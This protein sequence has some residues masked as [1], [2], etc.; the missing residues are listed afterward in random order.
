MLIGDQTVS[1]KFISEYK[2]FKLV[3]FF[4]QYIEREDNLGKVNGRNCGHIKWDTV[5]INSLTLH[6]PLLIV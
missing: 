4:D 1:Y 6:L 3:M 2:F 5:Y